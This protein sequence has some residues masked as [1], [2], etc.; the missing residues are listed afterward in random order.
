MNLQTCYPNDVSMARAPRLQPGP[1]IRNCLT[2]FSI[3]FF[4]IFIIL[5][6]IA[7]A[8]HTQDNIY[9]RVKFQTNPAEFNALL[10]A[11]LPLDDASISRS[12]EV[13]AELSDRDIQVL[14][15]KGISHT[16]LI[17]DLSRF[18]VERNEAY[19]NYS[20]ERDVSSE[21]PVPEDFELGSMGGFCTHAEMIAHLDNMY[22]KYPGLITEKAVAGT[23]LE[24]REIY[25]VKISDNPNQA[26]DEPEI[27][28][29]GMHH[30]REPIGMQLLL[31]YM[32]YLLE[33]YDTDEE[34]QYLV[35]N[36]EMYFIPVVNVDGYIYNE[37]TN[38]NGGGMWRKTRRDNGN[39]SYGVDAN[40]N[41]GYMW[42]YDNSGSS[43]DPW[44]ET[45]RGPYEFSEPCVQTLR[46]F[47]IDHAFGITLNYHSY[48]NLLLYPWGYIPD[49][50]P[51]DE[52][53][54]TWSVH[55]TRDNGYT[56]GPGSTT[57]YPSNGGSDDWMYGEQEEKELIYAY[58]PE[59]G[60]S[61]DGFWPSVGRIVPLCQENMLANFL[62]AH[63]TGA[64]AT[65]E[66]QSP[67]ALEEL[68]GNIDFMIQRL[69]LQDEATYTVSLDPLSPEI[70]AVGDPVAFDQL[71]LLEESNGSISYTLDP[72]IQSGTVV[73]FLL[74]L[75]NG[76]YAFTD[77]LRKAFG[78]Q[79]IIFED[80][81][82]NMEN[83]TSVH[84][85]ITS[86]AYHSAPFSIT[87]S[88][89][90]N[91]NSYTNSSVTTIQEID[92]G[93]AV[94]AVLNFWARWDIEA[95]WD[96]A[97]V[98]VSTNNGATW[99]PLEGNYTKTGN[100][101]Q[102][103]GQPLYDG[104]QLSW[105]EEEISLDDFLGEQI[106]LRF[107]IITDAYVNEDGFYFDDL[108]VGIIPGGG[109]GMTGPDKADAVFDIYPNPA[110]RRININTLPGHGDPY[111]L[112]VF[113]A[114]GQH[115]EQSQIP[116]GSSKLDIR[117]WHPG[118][119]YLR[120]HAPGM[121]TAV[122]KLVVY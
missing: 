11:G 52:V 7:A 13:I 72:A 114:H 20:I 107:T 47:C 8:G 25:W 29:N 74:S 78:E 55:M 14:T 30:A 15:E 45:Y 99:T 96:Y 64:Y 105:V 89:N 57:I 90:G 58:T 91:Y 112:D 26:E 16:V 19:R 49:P 116:A 31:Y 117:G 60:N 65:V 104:T 62:A 98:K 2:N 37:S 110:T 93:D 32:Y 88:P 108:S 5:I 77:T 6:M 12:Y 44:D 120:M 61:N 73:E 82:N 115:L 81:G 102:A 3:R 84:W 56:Y 106:L 48:S 41:Y 21:Y 103:P 28:Y 86:E 23:T 46:D 39:G 83:W 59:V 18:Y 100:S 50:C 51:D 95:G 67:P 24:G 36:R 85:N 111:I 34:V 119:Y 121:K 1:V 75:D 33:N 35:N 22:S 40:R 63:F 122:N 69:G 76:T 87:D 94:S 109:V 113:N 42:G 4:G 53:F 10:R 38:P 70:L 97:Q 101:N 118:V 43:P 71:E 66:D 92:L 17:S 68:D 79:E 9:A 54:Q 80:D 27:F